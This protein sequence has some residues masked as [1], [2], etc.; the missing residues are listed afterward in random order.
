MD[1]LEKKLKGYGSGLDPCVKEEQIR[2]V[3]IK[4]QKAFYDS[5]HGEAVGW[6]TFLMEQAIYIRKRWWL[7]Q[8]LLLAGLWWILYLSDSGYVAQHSMGVIAPVFVILLIP[9]LWK[10]R[11][12]GSVEIEGAAYFSLRQIYAARMLLFAMVDV[13]LLGIF[14]GAVLGTA[15][16]TVGVWDMAIHFFLPLNVSCC[17]CFGTLY[18]RRV[19]SEYA[20]VGLCLAWLAVWMLIILDEQIYSAVSKTVWAGAVTMSLLFLAAVVYRKL[21]SCGSGWEEEMVWS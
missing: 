2:A 4:S 18:G 17:I 13:L 9:E 7:C 6:S 10:N 11:S 8:L 12:S 1:F 3:M 20:A 5:L 19:H 16:T 21:K 14:T 15:Q